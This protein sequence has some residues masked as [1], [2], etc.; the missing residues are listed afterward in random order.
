MKQR[1]DCATP[2]LARLLVL[3]LPLG[4]A[5]QVD[6]A[7]VYFPGWLVAAISGVAASY[8]IVIGLGRRPGTRGLADSG[9]LFLSLAVGIA[10][11]VWWLGFSG[12]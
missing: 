5:P 11:A 8:L 2:R 1:V 4:C 6:V 9:L 10:L 3:A 7:G 12:F